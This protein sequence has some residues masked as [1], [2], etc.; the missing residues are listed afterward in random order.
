MGGARRH[1]QPAPTIGKAPSHPGGAHSHSDPPRCEPSSGFPTIPL[2]GV[3]ETIRALRGISETGHTCRVGCGQNSNPGPSHCQVTSIL[4]SEIYWMYMQGKQG[5]RHTDFNSWRR[6]E[7]RGD[8]G[9]ANRIFS[10]FTTIGSQSPLPSST[11]G[12]LASP[13]S[14]R[15]GKHAAGPSPWARVRL[16]PCLPQIRSGPSTC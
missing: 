3:G 13:I 10:A 16:V 14:L 15:E 9:F 5:L 2:P 1:P 6:F 11:T 8:Q 4:M 12:Q 7:G